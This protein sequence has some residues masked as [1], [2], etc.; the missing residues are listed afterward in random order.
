MDFIT[1][2]VGVATALIVEGFKR[3]PQIPI[4]AG[5]TARLRTAAV[6]LAFL[7]NVLNA[8]IAQDVGALEVLGGTFASYLVSY[9]TYRGVIRKPESAPVDNQPA[10]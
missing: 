5:Q 2:F 6:A 10:G 1:A 4:A 7:G 9:L 3:L 8:W